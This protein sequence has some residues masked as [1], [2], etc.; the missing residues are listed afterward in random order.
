MTG[1]DTAPSESISATA[2]PTWGDRHD[3]ALMAAIADQRDDAALAELYD[4]HGGLAFRV[5][6]GMLGERGAAEDVVQETFLAVWRNAD[7][8][9]PDRGAVRAWLMTIL[10]NAAID[11]RRGRF[12]REQTDVPLADVAYSL[13]SHADDPFAHASATL[14]AES[15]RHSLTNLPREQRQVIELAFFNGLTHVEVAEQVG[16]PL[17]TV[18]GRMRLGLTKLRTLLNDSITPAPLLDEARGRPDDP[19]RTRMSQ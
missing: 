17:G 19:T 2:S 16:S 9:R 7:R 6:Y 11:R 5:A 8:Y 15:I 10:R 18:K 12:R 14:D 1:H 13:E 4:R 3:H